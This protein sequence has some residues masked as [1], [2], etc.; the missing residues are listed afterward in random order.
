VLPAHAA[1]ENLLRHDRDDFYVTNA[2]ARML[3]QPKDFMTT[4]HSLI[5]AVTLLV[6][7]ISVTEAEAMLMAVTE[8]TR[9]IG[10]CMATGAC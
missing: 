5:A 10:I 8:C 1:I 3:A 7:T 6:D 4:M 2:T 9:E